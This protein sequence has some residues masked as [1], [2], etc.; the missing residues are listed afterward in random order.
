MVV[1]V[2][3]DVLA[4]GAALFGLEAGALRSL[5]GMDGAVFAVQQQGRDYVIKYNP[6]PADKV[7]TV[8]EKHRFIHYLAEHGVR[9]A[10]PLPSRGG[11]LVEVVPG[12]SAHY[13]ITLYN[14]APGHHVNGRD[15][16][17]VTPALFRLWGRTL[18][19]MHALT[20]AYP[21]W[22]NDGGPAEPPTAIMGWPQEQRS[23]ADWCQDGEVRAQWLALN[24]TLA[25][26]RRAVNHPI[27]SRM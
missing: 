12:E 16:A 13:C 15:P 14:K 4:A 23:F 9:V 24:E 5:G 21:T 17:Q 1:Q 2:S 7:A 18:G 22:R 6:L 3:S 19:Q 26:C 20:Q 27:C 8:V 11:N 10:A 25:V